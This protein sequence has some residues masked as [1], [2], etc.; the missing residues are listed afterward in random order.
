MAL[1]RP[2]NDFNSREHPGPGNVLLLIEAADTSVVRDLAV[3]LPLY[4][5]T[6]IREAWLVD[7]LAEIFGSTRDRT[8]KATG[9]P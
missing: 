7:L 5:L 9:R 8:A 2:H 1:V 6:S 4:T 3:K